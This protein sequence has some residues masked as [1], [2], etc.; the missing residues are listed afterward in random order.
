MLALTGRG[1]STCQ[2]VVSILQRCRIGRARTNSSPMQQKL[3]S[4]SKTAELWLLYVSILIAGFFV[5]RGCHPKDRPPFLPRK[6]KKKAMKFANLD[7]EKGFT[8]KAAAASARKAASARTLDPHSK[9]FLFL[10][11]KR[12]SSLM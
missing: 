10:P 1:C 11:S 4:L 8:R 6:K 2:T 12:C 9:I 5:G 7:G 3:R